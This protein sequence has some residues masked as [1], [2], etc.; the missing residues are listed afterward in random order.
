MLTLSCSSLLQHQWQEG[1]LEQRQGE[2]ESPS[3]GNA[4]QKA[5]LACIL[6]VA[7]SLRPLTEHQ[8]RPWMPEKGPSDTPL[9]DSLCPQ[10]PLSSFSS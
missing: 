2:E 6:L 9:P 1:F 4:L 5:L 10:G 7:T 3:S 8:A